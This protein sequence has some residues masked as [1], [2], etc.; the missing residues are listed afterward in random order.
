VSRISGTGCGC[1]SPGISIYSR[2]ALA[3]TGILFSG[4]GISSFSIGG[5]SSAMTNVLGA[6]V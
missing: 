1:Y 3:A 5:T 4:R 6:K 2:E